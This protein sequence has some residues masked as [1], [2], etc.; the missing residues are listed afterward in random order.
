MKKGGKYLLCFSEIMPY[1]IIPFSGVYFWTITLHFI[2]RISTL[3]SKY[4]ITRS[5][6]LLF[7][8]F[9][10]FQMLTNKTQKINIAENKTNYD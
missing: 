6:F 3:P 10:L 9:F 2:D 1:D 4:S 5:D 7:Y 8:V